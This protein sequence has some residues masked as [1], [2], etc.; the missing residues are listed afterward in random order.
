MMKVTI[1]PKRRELTPLEKLDL[2]SE[3]EQTKRT[4]KAM[5]D[6]IKLAKSKGALIEEQIK[7]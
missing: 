5:D 4:S 3:K 6:L 2:L 1:L 7:N